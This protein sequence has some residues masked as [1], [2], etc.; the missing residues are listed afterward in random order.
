[1]ELI[2][3]LYTKNPA[4]GYLQMTDQLRRQGHAVNKKRVYRLMRLM[5]IR[6]VQPRPYTSKHQKEHRKYP[7]LLRDKEIIRPQEAWATDITYIPMNRGFMYLMSVMDWYS[8]FVLSWE[9][10]NVMD[11]DFCLHVLEK[12]FKWGIPA[13]FNSDQ[14]SQFTSEAFTNKL[15]DKNIRIS[16]DGKGRA[17][18]NVFIERLWRTVKYECVY[19]YSFEDGFALER[20]LTKFFH[21]YNYERGHS[22]FDYK[23]PSEIYLSYLR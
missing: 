15:L 18:D 9:V 6:S 5:N 20:E 13:I 3:R 21:Y 11:V 22:A 10:S 12:S 8:R 16:M 2:D 14:G 4:L 17:I 23:T 7:Y 1:M 19:L